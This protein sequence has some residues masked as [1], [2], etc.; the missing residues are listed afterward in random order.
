MADIKSEK[1]FLRPHQKCGNNK[2][3]LF[4]VVRQLLSTA[5]LLFT[6]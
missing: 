1:I 5:F 4:S 6:F 3:R 2:Y